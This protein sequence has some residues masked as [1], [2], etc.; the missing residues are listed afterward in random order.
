MIVNGYCKIFIYIYIYI[1]IR[2]IADL[3]LVQKRYL[4]NTMSTFAYY[5]PL[6]NV[7][8]VC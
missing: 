8:K 1:Y 6:L 3:Y 4:L 5:P 7:V 2:L